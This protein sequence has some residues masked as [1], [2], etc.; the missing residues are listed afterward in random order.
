MCSIRCMCVAG[1]VFKLQKAFFYQ[2]TS[3][4]FHLVFIHFLRL[5]MLLL[6]LSSPGW[7]YNNNDR[8]HP[9]YSELKWVFSINWSKMQVWARTLPKLKKTQF[10][11]IVWFA[12]QKHFNRLQTNWVII[13]FSFLYYYPITVHLVPTPFY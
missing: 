7:Q 6:E 2:A 12:M 11:E 8:N 1:M 13:C 9:F 10:S 4:K 3:N 5:E